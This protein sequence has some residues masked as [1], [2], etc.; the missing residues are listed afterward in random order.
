MGKK[1]IQTYGAERLLFLLCDINL[2]NN[3][4][5]YSIKE[6]IMDNMYDDEMRHIQ[7]LVASQ[8][9]IRQGRAFFVCVVDNDDKFQNF[10]SASTLSMLEVEGF[11]SLI[12]SAVMHLPQAQFRDMNDED[13]E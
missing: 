3:S 5:Y 10:Y 6:V 2:I 13:D 1:I 7:M 11:E 9:A 4:L 8:D 12:R